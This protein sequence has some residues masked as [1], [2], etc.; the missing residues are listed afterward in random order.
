MAVRSK[1]RRRGVSCSLVLIGIGVC[2][3]G[4]IA[5]YIFVRA[6]L[7]RDPIPTILDPRHVV[8]T[9]ESLASEIAIAPSELDIPPVPN[10]EQRSIV[11][12]VTSYSPPV[13]TTSPLAPEVPLE[14]KISPSVLVVGGTD[15]SGTRRVVQILTDLGV[16]LH[17]M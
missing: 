6:L 14:K 12:L 16:R 13:P 9:Y 17:L 2:L 11:T 15:G 1:G 7:Y 3:L 10:H 5:L 8:N 4:F